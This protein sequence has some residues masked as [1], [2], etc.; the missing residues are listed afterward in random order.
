MVTAAAT[1]KS[2]EFSNNQ[3]P[4]EAVMS[5]G[6]GEVKSGWSLQNAR[7]ESVI[8]QLVLAVAPSG[9]AG[10][11]VLPAKILDKYPTELVRWPCAVSRSIKDRSGVILS[12]HQRPER[13]G[14]I[15]TFAKRRTDRGVWNGQPL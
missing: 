5:F 4:A 10:E 2:V 12:F 11:A 6:M 9:G 14:T 3:E 8:G 7:L 13:R 15:S 1:E